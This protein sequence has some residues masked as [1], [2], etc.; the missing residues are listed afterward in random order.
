MKGSR[1]RRRPVSSVVRPPATGVPHPGD[2]KGR[3]NHAGTSGPVPA[4]LS[5]PSQLPDYEGD[6][7]G[8][9]ESGKTAVSEAMRAIESGKAIVEDAILFSGRFD[10]NGR[11]LRESKAGQKPYKLIRAHGQTE[12]KDALESSRKQW[13]ALPA[14]IAEAIGRR[15]KV[16]K[17][18]EAIQQKS[19]RLRFRE[20]DFMSNS[21]L[22]SIMSADPN[23]YTEYTPYFSGP[24]YKQQYWDYFKGHARAYELYNHSPIAHRIVDLLVQYSM[25]RGFKTECKD[26]ILNSLWKVFQQKNKITFKMRK[27]WAKEYLIYGENFIDVLRWVSID[28]STIYDIV[29]EGYGEYIDDVLYYQQMFQCLHGDTRIALLDGTTPTIRE[30]AERGGEYWVYSY[31]KETGRIVPGKAVKTWKQ[32]GQ[33]RC[34]KVT[35]DSGESVIASYDHPFL[36]R[37]GRY[38]WAE[39][40]KSG[41]SLMPLYRKQGYERVWQPKTGWE[42]THHMVAGEPPRGHA[43]HHKN[44]RLTDNSPGNLET[45]THNEHLKHHAAR[46]CMAESSWC[47]KAPG[48]GSEW[49]KKQ[50]LAA[51]VRWA[52]DPEGR[53]AISDRAK[54]QWASPEMRAKMSAGISRSKN[55]KALEAEAKASAVVNHKVASVEAAGMHD[56][57]DLTVDNH[58]N[59]ALACGV[60]THNTA[61][62]MY[63]GLAVPNVAKQQDS[64][65]G[66]YIIRQIPYDHVI[67]IKTGVVSV[68]KRGRS[69]LYPVLTYL[70]RLRD[71][72]DAQVLGEQLRAAF[73]FDDTVEGSDTDVAAHGAKYAYIPVSPSIFVHNAAVKRETMAPMQGVTASAS[74]VVQELISIIATSAGIPKEHMNSA[75]AGGS[76]RATAVVGSEPFTKV[77]EDLQE[78]FSD[79]MHRIIERFCADNSIPYDSEQWSITFPSV[80]KDSL[81]DRLKNIAFCEA[82]GWLSSRTCATM[83]ATEMDRDDYDYDE[84]MKLSAQDG[85]KKLAMGVIPPAPQVPN[86]RFGGASPVVDDEEEGGDNPIHGKGKKDLLRSHKIL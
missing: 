25:G 15:A 34:V 9:I 78:D 23:Q 70:K 37:D 7:Y 65:L 71:A 66:R 12:Y 54:A 61:T 69:V 83:A 3:G 10:T 72:L 76:N 44:H 55:R 41:D 73:V 56:V 11:M 36:T 8:P 53:K 47:F 33:K 42:L 2:W 40:L 62:Q 22:G 85:R 5:I 45:L 64:K 31:D 63:A 20:D 1:S 28:P 32:Q 14:R 43:V 79:L 59:F 18:I 57:Y 21:D 38:V 6:I 81:T 27:F 86:G 29:C 35:L 26:E 74:N 58:H 50:G 48:R 46:L 82:N 30:L 19:D 16:R 52:R 60:F 77:I 51:R 84:E 68:E 75:L 49:R 4:S 13:A 67:H 24:F 80:V 39:N 17:A